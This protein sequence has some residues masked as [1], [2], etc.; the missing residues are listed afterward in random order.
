MSE[1]NFQGDVDFDTELAAEDIAAD[2]SFVINHFGAG[3]QTAAARKYE[4]VVPVACTLVTYRGRAETA[5]TG[6]TMILDVNKNDV[7][8][9]TTQGN[10]PTAAIGSKDFSTTAPDITAFAAGDRVSID[11]DQIGS[12]IAGSDLAFTMLFKTELVD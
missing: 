8:L 4:A 6:S 7:T 5:P 1:T 2:A 10:R 12:T 3:A 11:V 9:F